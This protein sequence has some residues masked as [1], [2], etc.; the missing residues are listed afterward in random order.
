MVKTFF[1]LNA[2][3]WLIIYAFSIIYSMLALVQNTKYTTKNKELYTLM[4]YFSST[5]E[6]Y[7]Y[8]I[9]V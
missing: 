1:N 5:V 4:P 9:R 6:H 7:N 2:L 8:S 3:T